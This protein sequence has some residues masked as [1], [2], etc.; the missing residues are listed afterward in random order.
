MQAGRRMFSPKR[1]VLSLQLMAERWHGKG[2]NLKKMLSISWTLLGIM[3]T[4]RLMPSVSW[5]VKLRA[6]L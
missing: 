6:T 2:M 4:R 3:K 5:K 1:G